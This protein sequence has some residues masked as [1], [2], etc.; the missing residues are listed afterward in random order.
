MACDGSGQ[1]SNGR[2]TRA[3]MGCSNCSEA[4]RKTNGGNQG[5][6][7]DGTYEDPQGNISV[8]WFRQK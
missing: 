1:V 4:I 5:H 6:I 2:A 3:C 7:D 8:N